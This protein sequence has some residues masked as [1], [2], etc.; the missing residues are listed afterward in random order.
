MIRIFLFFL[1]FAFVNLS[2][3]KE[4]KSEKKDLHK[5]ILVDRNSNPIPLPEDKLIVVNFLA[6][7]CSS[8]MRELPVIK[9][10]LRE[11]KFKGRFQFIGI[12]IDSDKGDFYD[13]DFPIYPGHKQ[14][15]VRFPV[16]GT[17]TTYIITPKGKKLIIIHG[18]VTEENFR[19][20]LKQAVEKA[21][22]LSA[23][24]G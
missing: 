12:V 6:Y 9:K 5:Y 24:E 11:K 1:V 23:K 13:P 22:R 2:C 8:C 14:N 18:A 21:E 17:P 20:F 19:K 4:E 3:Q 15:F 7:S 16:P 10:V